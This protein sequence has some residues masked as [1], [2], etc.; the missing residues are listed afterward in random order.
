MNELDAV[1]RVLRESSGGDI[2]SDQDEEN[3]QGEVSIVDRQR[4]TDLRAS[5]NPLSTMTKLSESRVALREG[6]GKDPELFRKGS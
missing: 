6:L 2:Y 3:L 1:S 4:P 5:H